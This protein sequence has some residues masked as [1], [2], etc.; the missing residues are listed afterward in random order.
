M[1]A[2]WI[3]DLLLSQIVDRSPLLLV[4]LNPRN[5]VLAV[6]AVQTDP[7]PYY[8]VGFFRLI[9]TD[10]VN[11]L[12]GFWFGE[13]AIAWV[14]RRSRTYGPLIDQ[15]SGGF[16]S[17]AYPIIFFAPNNIV[18]ALSGATGVG[19]RAFFALNISGTLFRFGLVRRLG[20]RF[21]TPI[22]SIVDF[23][24]ANRLPVFIVSA[25]GVAWMAFGEFRGGDSELHALRDLDRQMGDESESEADSGDPPGSS[26]ES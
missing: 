17:A 18:C 19:V 25:L 15:I 9:A 7:L 21:E 11:Y 10:P 20:E 8:L 2:S 14:R 3:G 13:R 23:I 24:A 26:D 22:N 1:A 4:A 16:R 6:A 5:R 12:L